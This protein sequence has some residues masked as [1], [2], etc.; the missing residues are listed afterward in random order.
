MK[1]YVAHLRTSTAEGQTPTSR[2]E[3]TQ[4]IAPAP[5]AGSSRVSARTSTRRE[6]AQLDRF[7]SVSQEVQTVHALLHMFLMLVRERKHQRLHLWMEEA[8]KSGIAELRSFVAGIE[9]DYDAVKAALR[10]PWSHDHIA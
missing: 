3:R 9:R 4:A 1:A 5:S 2:K 10:L 6:Q 8:N 7:L